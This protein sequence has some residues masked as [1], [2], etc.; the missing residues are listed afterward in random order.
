MVDG[1]TQDV[2]VAKD[3]GVVMRGDLRVDEEATRRL[4]HE[5]AAGPSV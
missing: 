4:S 2:R 1:E 3:Y 5:H